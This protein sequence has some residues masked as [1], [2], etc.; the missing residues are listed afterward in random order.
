[1]KNYREHI[2]KC[3]KHRRNKT[4]FLTDVACPS[5][6]EVQIETSGFS[7]NCGGGLWATDAYCSFCGWTGPFLFIKEEKIRYHD[8]DEERRKQQ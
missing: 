5:C 6:N 4:S 7:T 2:T 3:L 8:Y 1:M